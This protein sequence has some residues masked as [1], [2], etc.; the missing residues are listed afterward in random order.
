[1]YRPVLLKLPFAMPQR[2]ITIFDDSKCV[3]SNCLQATGKRIVIHRRAY[4]IVLCV[5]TINTNF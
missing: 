3:L 5:L 2:V 1:M 4:Y